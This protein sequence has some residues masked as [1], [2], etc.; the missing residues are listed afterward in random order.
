MEIITIPYGKGEQLLQVNEKNLVAVLRPKEKERSGLEEKEIVKA[1]LSDPINSVELCYLAKEKKKIVLITSDHTRPVPS[2]TTVPVLLKEIRKWNH[3]ADVTILVATGMH[4]PTTHEEL[5]QKFGDEIVR[6]E[7]I[8]IHDAFDKEKMAYYGKLPSGGELWLNG[9]LK[10]AELVISEGF[11]EPHFFA[12]FSGGRK[13]ILPGIAYAETV[14]YNHNAG[15]ISNSH[16]KQ[17]ILK[18]NPIHED[19]MYAAK[20][21]G[22]AFIMNVILDSE[23]R[24]VAAVAGNPE[25]AHEKGCQICDERMRLLPVMADIVVTSNG[26]YPLDQNI[27]QS[28]KGM[29]AAEACVRPGGVIIMNAALRDGHGGECFFKWF[30]ERASAEEVMREIERVPAVRTSPDQWEAQ[31]LARIQ[32]KAHC[33]VVTGK[34]NRVL[35]EKMHME[36]MPDVNT[37]LLKAYERLG[38]ESSVTVI[39]DGVGV[40]L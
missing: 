5:I 13:S 14:M 10:E 26:G 24:I 28:V 4:R 6:K 8:V 39:P 1:A 2:K 19:M 18:G 20:Q 9:L 3:A 36:W 23:K 37:A 32:M 38:A 34:E 33:M 17:G 31:I 11:I 21:A 15:F 29:T 16:A 7:K 35:V 30:A 12:G 25:D 40:I 27:Y 22:L